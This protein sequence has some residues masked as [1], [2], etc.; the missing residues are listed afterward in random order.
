MVSEQRIFDEIMKEY[1]DR[2]SIRVLDP[3]TRKDYEAW[4][5]AFM[6][7]TI[8]AYVG[9]ISKGAVEQWALPQVRRNLVMLAAFVIH[10][11]LKIDMMLEEDG[12]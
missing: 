9:A 4:G 3:I 6:A 2:P 10:T 11:I 5:Q 8:S 1:E 12:D 7:C